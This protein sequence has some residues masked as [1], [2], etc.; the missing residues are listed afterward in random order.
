[1]RREMSSYGADQLLNELIAHTQ[2]MRRSMKKRG[3]DYIEYEKIYLELDKLE[4]IL[5]DEWI[6]EKEKKESK[7]TIT[8]RKDLN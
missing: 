8:G 4:S 1:M 6:S 5:L 7:A 3:M 2:L